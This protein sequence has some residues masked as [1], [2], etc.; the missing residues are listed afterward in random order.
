MVAIG[1]YMM[2]Y[3]RIVRKALRM[4]TSQQL[5]VNDIKYVYEASSS[6]SS[7]PFPLPLAFIASSY[8]IVSGISQGVSKPPVCSK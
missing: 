6:S 7:F 8:M 3:L 4:R 5:F 1:V 2:A